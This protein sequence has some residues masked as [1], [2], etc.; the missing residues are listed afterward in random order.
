MVSVYYSQTMI[1]WSY[2][3]T[4]QLLQGYIFVITGEAGLNVCLITCRPGM[5]TNDSWCLT[6]SLFAHSL[7]THHS[8]PTTSHL[9][10]THS[11]THSHTHSL[12]HTHTLTHSLTHSLSPVELSSEDCGQRQLE[13]SGLSSLTNSLTHSLTLLR[14]TNSLTHTHIHSLNTTL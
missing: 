4:K 6:C 8:L 5:R 2:R 3:R 12:T 1:N 11:L 7:I 9:L 14:L 10:L 13:W